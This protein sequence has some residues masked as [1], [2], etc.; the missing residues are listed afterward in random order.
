[1]PM[2]GNAMHHHDHHL[3]DDE[4]LLAI[5][6]ELS[7]DRGRVAETHLAR[8]VECRTRHGQIKQS[9]ATF[10]EA[11]R[12]SLESPVPD[13][14]AR[15]RMQARLHDESA[16]LERSWI[17]RFLP[18]LS[19]M[20]RW[21]VMCSTL[22]IVALLGAAV[23]QSRGGDNQTS[24]VVSAPYARPV[25]SLTPGA[26]LEIGTHE[27]CRTGP[28]KRTRLPGILRQQVLRAYDMEAVSVDEYELDYLITPELGGAPDARNLWPQRYAIPIW[29]AYAKDQLEALLPKLVCAGELD[30]VTAQRDIAVDWITA[31]QKYFK[32]AYPLGPRARIAR[33]DDRIEFDDGRLIAYFETGSPFAPTIRLISR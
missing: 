26:T 33:D 4:L 13:S 30:L 14:I 3:A 7:P 5:D 28:D 6:H 20:P 24:F 21:A 19:P 25:A 8:C 32:T 12:R 1:M 27:L 2:W 22:T 17:V 10:G 9:S 31:Y 29:N 11:Y 23:H 18:V 16:R 15:A